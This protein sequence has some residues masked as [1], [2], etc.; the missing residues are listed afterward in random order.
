[1]NV[2]IRK[3]K[4]FDVEEILCLYHS[5]IGTDGCTWSDEYPTRCDVESDLE[6]ASLYVLYDENN[7]IL[8]VA[9]A[10]EDS[11]LEHLKCW[12]TKIL[13]VCD[14]ARIGILSAYQG[15]GFGE[16]LVKYIERDVVKRGFDGIHFLVS[17]TNP[18][19]LALYDKLDYF[20]VGDAYMYDVDWYCYEKILVKR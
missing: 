15:R 14:L 17:K 3:A 1:M 9:A 11:E 4:V 5:L 13:R 18:R 10:G 12:N 6:K 19:A 16:M 8:G 7:K 2:N 20:N